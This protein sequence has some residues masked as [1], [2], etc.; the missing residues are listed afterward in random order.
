MVHRI[1]DETAYFILILSLCLIFLSGCSR[2][3]TGP[4]TSQDYAVS[5]WDTGVSVQKPGQPDISFSDAGNSAASINRQLRSVDVSP[6]QVSTSSPVTSYPTATPEVVLSEWTTRSSRAYVSPYAV[7]T[8]EER[9]LNSD[10]IA[11]VRPP[12]ISA[13]SV[14]RRRSHRMPGQSEFIHSAAFEFRFPVTE[15]IKGSGSSELVVVSSNYSEKKI[16]Q[17]GEDLSESGSTTIRSAEEAVDQAEKLLKERNAEWD[18]RSAIVFLSESTLEEDSGD[19]ASGSSDSGQTYVFPNIYYGDDFSFEIPGEFRERYYLHGISKLWLPAAD[20]SSP[21]SSGASGQSSDDLLFLA[22]SKPIQGGAT[23]SAGSGL[24]TVSLGEIRSTITKVDQL[25]KAGEDISG[26]EECLKIKYAREKERK[27]YAAEFGLSTEPVKHTIPSG[28][29]A[30]TRLE[31][32]NY[33]YAGMGYG[34]HWTS[35]PDKDLFRF[36][37]TD[38]TGTVLDYDETSRALVAYYQNPSTVR[39]LPGGVYELNKHEQDVQYMPCN[40]RGVDDNPGIK[41]IITVESPAGTLH[42][43]FFDPVLDTSTSAVG[44]DSTNGVLKPAAFTDAG[45]ATTTIGSLEWKSGTVKMNVSP[46]TALGGHILDFIELDGTVSLS[47]DTADATADA[48]NNTLSW[49]VASQPW[50]D[51]DTLMLRIRR[52]PNRPPVFDTSTYAFT[53]REDASAFHIIGFVSASDPD[54]GDS[55]WYYITGGNEAGRFQLGANNGELLVWKPLAYETTSSYTLSVEARDGKENGT[56]TATVEISV[57][58]VDE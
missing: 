33:G 42:E 4:E 13:K 56:A 52:G 37:L 23:G 48:A 43:A 35:G 19:S 12:T 10:V 27:A 14:T 39:P 24:P 41:H 11:L 6:T 46:H 21:T 30:G 26:Y 58:A 9:V 2:T 25:L 51:G 53:V 49:S 8:L 54:A 18:D 28:S 57:T 15:Y 47:L 16:I 38:E 34:K 20:E 7:A 36:D 50:E 40:Y 5:P 22:D 1:L 55:P 31:E 3:H 29:S 17:T 44:A 45:G 32:E